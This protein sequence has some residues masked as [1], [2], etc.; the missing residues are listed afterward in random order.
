M[1]DTIE[2]AVHFVQLKLGEASPRLFQI[3]AVKAFIGV[4]QVTWLGLSNGTTCSFER[5][6]LALKRGQGVRGDWRCHPSPKMRLPNLLLSLFVPGTTAVNLCQ[7]VL[8]AE[9]DDKFID[10]RDQR[11]AGATVRPGEQ[12]ENIR[13]MGLDL[14]KVPFGSTLFFISPHGEVSPATLFVTASR[15]ST[16]T[17]MVQSS[18]K[19]GDTIGA[20]WFVA[21]FMDKI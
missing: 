9:E 3:N 21:A 10:E 2:D 4:G 15:E 11:P 20:G 7:V 16:L 5:Q 18:S 12:C 1:L 17:L 6:V 14:E 8:V 13:L 19:R